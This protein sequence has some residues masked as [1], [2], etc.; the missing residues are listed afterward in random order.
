MIEF[1]SKV[2]L[3]GGGRTEKSVH[4]DRAF[5]GEVENRQG[6]I[7]YVPI[8]LAKKSIAEYMY[9]REWLEQTLN[10]LRSLPDKKLPIQ[11]IVHFK[12]EENWEE[13]LPNYAAVYIGGADNTYRLVNNIRKGGFAGP[14]FGYVQNGGC[15]YGG[16]SGAIALGK[17][18][19]VFGEEM[20]PGITTEEGLALVGK[21]SVFCH[22]D[23]GKFDITRLSNFGTTNGSPILLIPEGAGMVIQGNTSEVIGNDGTKSCVLTPDGNLFEYPAGSLINLNL[24]QKHE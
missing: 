7:L 22:Y 2:F 10:P 20:P 21:Y 8:G 23:E 17:Y 16:S 11:M 14:L 3:A 6:P 4:I 18:V 9:C 13:V 5:V 24:P 19:S 12:A 1:E 15:V